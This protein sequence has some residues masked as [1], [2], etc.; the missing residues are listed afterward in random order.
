MAGREGPQRVV[1][2]RRLARPAD[3]PR[4]MQAAWAARALGR[5]AERHLAEGLPNLAVYAFD[6][7]GRAVAMDGRY[8]RDE[9]ELLMQSAAPLLP[10]GGQG[11][12]LDI[13]ANIGNHALFFASHFAEVLAFEPHPRTHALLQFNA[14]LHERVRCFAFGLSDAAGTATL[15]VPEGNAGMASLHGVPGA[16]RTVSCELRRL[17]DLPELQTRRVALVKIDVEGHEAAVLRGARAVLSRD[18]PLVV[19]EQAAAEIV[20]GS[21]PALAVLRELGYDRLW[22]LERRPAEGRWRWGNL[23]RRL[24]GGEHLRLV[25]AERLETRFHS[26]VVALP[27]AAPGTGG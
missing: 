19:L 14:G 25:E 22:T 17:D 16:A 8:E 11:V 12:C 4:R 6:H 26:M 3:V 23:L 2:E 18:R 9:L 24:L 1:G 10:H 20:G 15:A 5:Q 21:S 27:P 13:G 7:V